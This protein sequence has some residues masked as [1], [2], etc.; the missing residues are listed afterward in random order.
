MIGDRLRV[1]MVSRA[2]AA[3]HGVGGLERHV[4]DLVR[5]LLEREV[6]VT[7]VTRPAV[8]PDEE[9]AT[10]WL[11][12]PRLAI[13]AVP[14]WTF[15]FAGRRG[16]TVLDRNTAYLWFALRAGRRAARLLA[17]GRVDLI[18]GH[19]ASTLGAVWPA[20]SSPLPLV[21]TPHG[22]EEFG[23]TDS[24]RARLKR[25]AYRPLQGA[26][27]CCA[28][29]AARTLATDQSLV[30]AT[31]TNLR[32]AESSVVVV[33]NAVDLDRTDA[34]AG[35]RDGQASRMRHDVPEDEPVLL[36]VGRIEPNK[37]FDLLA[38]ALAQ[39]Q[40]RDRRR[41]WRWVVVGDG[42][43]RPTLE[44]SI[45]RGGLRERTVI[46][47]A[48][49]EAELHAWYEAATIF[50]HPTLYEGSSLVTLEAMAHRR[51]VVA[52]TAGGLP[53]KVRPGRNGWLVPPGN[54]A[55]LAG[56]VE[57]ALTSGSERLATLGLEGREIVEQ[58]FSLPSV[59][60]RLIG[61]YEEVRS[62]RGQ[63]GVG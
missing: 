9:A 14:Y 21:V 57:S 30:P 47:A 62:E 56:A 37:G 3:L 6:A 46:V 45:A 44:R 28:R 31:V 33:P 39:L 10:D 17:D 25:V 58:E 51:A 52:T 63:V 43:D 42:S 61:L 54:V 48:A 20:P 32:V 12:D 18:H 19:G 59:V 5:Q 16:T 36:S 24:S 22:M 29:H 35:P 49:T 2:S 40:A 15:P 27:R 34:L 1:A 26:V 8:R 38:D 23:G 11:R 13:Q 55:E 7:L 53:D 41:R 50:V 4:D 60:D